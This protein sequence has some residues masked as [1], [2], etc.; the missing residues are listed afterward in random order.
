MNIFRVLFLLF[1]GATACFATH[2]DSLQN[3]YANQ[4]ND[5]LKVQTGFELAEE[6]YGTNPERAKEIF[7]NNIELSKK[8]NYIFGLAESYGWLG[9]L[10]EHNG[11]YKQ[12][13][14][15]YYQAIAGYKKLNRLNDIANIYNNISSIYGAEGKRELSLQYAIKALK[16]FETLKEYQGI[17]HSCANIGK[18]Y[19]D[20]RNFT[21]ADR[22][23]KESV[24]ASLL[25]KIDLTIAWAYHNYGGFLF[26]KN[27]RVVHPHT[28]HLD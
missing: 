14:H 25:S 19:L 10:V 1:F 15:Y 27:E 6:I 3:A 21:K 17:S 2:I 4:K 16:L 9:Y 8:T 13:I 28:L 12:A 26:Y 24:Q 23:L 11:N 5:S 22:Y 18:I 7:L 20:S